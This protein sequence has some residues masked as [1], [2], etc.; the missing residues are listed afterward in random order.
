MDR[1]FP[2]AEQEKNVPSEKMCLQKK[3]AC[4]K[5]CCSS[6]KKANHG[7]FTVKKKMRH[8]RQNFQC[9][10][11]L[12]PATLFQGPYP[13]QESLEDSL[14]L[15]FGF[16]IPAWDS[17]QIH[18]QTTHTGKWNS[19]IGAEPTFFSGETL[20]PTGAKNVKASVL[21]GHTKTP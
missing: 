8:F 15:I 12:I 5:K 18:E 6:Q 11:C 17:G 19:K 1:H 9:F 7:H 4:R 16:V 21:N 10:R 20:N 2:C 13:V 3:L 14:H